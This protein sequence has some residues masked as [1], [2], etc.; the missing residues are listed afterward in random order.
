VTDPLADWYRH[1]VVIRRFL[2]D[3]SYG[4]TFATAE[5]IRGFV[6]GE[7]KLVR[8]ASGAEVVS[9]V[10]VALP[11]DTEWVPPQSE[12]DLP[13]VFGGRT[14]RVLSTAVGNGGGQPTPDHVEIFCE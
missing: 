1:P 5:T 11:A 4:P 10:Q 3:G 6:G 12:I 7:T 2:G 9:S 8:N 13:A 14:A